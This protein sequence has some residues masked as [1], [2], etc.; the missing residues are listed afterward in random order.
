ME[1]EIPCNNDFGSARE[2]GVNDI[3]ENGIVGWVVDV[4]NE[5]RLVF[6]DNVYGEYGWV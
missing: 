5:K 4:N 2:I 3:R 1:V 6:G